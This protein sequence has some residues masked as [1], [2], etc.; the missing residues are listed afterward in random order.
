MAAARRHAVLE[1]STSS[2]ASVFAG[3]VTIVIVSSCVKFSLSGLTREVG[4]D[5]HVTLC[6][7]IVRF[8]EA[9]RV[10]AAPE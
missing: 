8:V 1:T 5:T 2:A 9:E 10:L 3:G 7:R 6:R 4:C